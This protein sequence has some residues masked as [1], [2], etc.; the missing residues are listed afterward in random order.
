MYLLNTIVWAGEGGEVLNSFTLKK[1][2][3]P[4]TDKLLKDLFP[5]TIMFFLRF[6]LTRLLLSFFFISMA[7]CYALQASLKVCFM[8]F[9]LMILITPRLAQVVERWTAVQEV[10]VSSP[11]PAQH[12]ES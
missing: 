7:L 6:L 10:K 12:S 4:F 9:L 8:P 5:L 2:K 11:R 1:K 3:K